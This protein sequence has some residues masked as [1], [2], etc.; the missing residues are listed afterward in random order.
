MSCKFVVRARRFHSST[1][2][3]YGGHPT[4]R[5]TTCSFPSHPSPKR[6]SSSKSRSRSAK[7]ASC[8]I[9]RARQA[10]PNEESAYEIP[11]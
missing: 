5:I 6:P 9:Y 8:H 4:K 2:S 11:I 3:P 1:W 10:K 7:R